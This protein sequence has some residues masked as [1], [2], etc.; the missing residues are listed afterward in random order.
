MVIELS[1][2]LGPSGA[3]AA[4]A[5]YGEERVLRDKKENGQDFERFVISTSSLI[6]QRVAYIIQYFLFNFN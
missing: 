1:G 4:S 5:A 3:S 2:M 6:P